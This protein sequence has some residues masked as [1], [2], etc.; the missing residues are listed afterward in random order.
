[1]ISGIFR[2][3]FTG[4]AGS[5][6]GMFVLRDGGVAGA[7]V[8]GAVYDGTYTDDPSAKE[9]KINV[10]MRAP[11]GITPVQTGV[12]LPGPI[13]IPITATIP[14]RDLESENPSLLQTPLGA[15]NAIF[16]KVRDV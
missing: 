3:A 7:D 6:F 11:A 1:M 2:M 8:G 16:K 10:S 14:Y 15:V 4:A 9:I 5:G 12:P 13:D